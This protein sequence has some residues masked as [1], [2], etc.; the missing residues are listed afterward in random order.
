MFKYLY[1]SNGTDWV[2]G[3]LNGLQKSLYEMHERAEA[4]CRRF[5]LPDAGH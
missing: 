3:A 4:N 1:R 5:F 2:S